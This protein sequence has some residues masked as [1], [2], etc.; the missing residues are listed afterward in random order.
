MESSKT[1]D[2]RREDSSKHEAR[3]SKREAESRQAESEWNE[4]QKS[5]IVD[6]LFGVQLVS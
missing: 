5:S 3:N 4:L 1:G 2:G 6:C